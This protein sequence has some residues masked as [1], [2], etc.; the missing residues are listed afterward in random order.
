MDGAIGGIDQ[1]VQ[2]AQLQVVNLNEFFELTLET[3][4]Q[5][6][7]ECQTPIF[8]DINEHVTFNQASK[9]AYDVMSPKTRASN[10]PNTKDKP[11]KKK[12]K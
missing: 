9:Q 1:G 5:Q 12:Y 8:Y 3:Q 6:S 11:N 4:R 10:L 7:H 2:L